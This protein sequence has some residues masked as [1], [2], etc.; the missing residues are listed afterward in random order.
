MLGCC[1]ARHARN[2]SLEQAGSI[3]CLPFASLTQRDSHF[4]SQMQ[5]FA[6]QEE[7]FREA[8]A[9]QVKMVS[10]PRQV[11]GRAVQ[12]APAKSMLDMFGCGA[13][14]RR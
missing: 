14:F 12:G 7:E 6:T 11:G 4:S 5:G 10:D 9:P 2:T 13:N 3:W 1:R 8:Y